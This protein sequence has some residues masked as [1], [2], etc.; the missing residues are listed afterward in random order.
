[1]TEQALDRS[2]ALVLIATPDAAK[3]YWV[4][5]EVRLFQ[6]RHTD[7]PPIVMLDAPRR[8]SAAD[9]MPPAL[10]FK[11]PFKLDEAGQVTGEPH[12]ELA[13]DPRPGADGLAVLGSRWW[14]V[15][16]GCFLHE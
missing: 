11:L 15:C 9:C 2:D 8:A 3:S 12:S 13:A 6:H 16:W 4:K 5:K 7:H 10:P 1:V 14:P